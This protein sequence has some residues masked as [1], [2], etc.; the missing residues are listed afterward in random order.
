MLH[1][2]HT[3]PACADA[4]ASTHASATCCLITAGLGSMF[5]SHELL[6][7]AVVGANCRL[8]LVCLKHYSTSATY[9]LLHTQPSGA[10]PP[11]LFHPCC[12]HVVYHRD[13][14]YSCSCCVRVFCS[15]TMLLSSQIVNRFPWTA[16]CMSE[17]CCMWWCRWCNSFDARLLWKPCR[18]AD[19]PADCT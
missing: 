14:R 12:R 15:L 5:N 16:A 18:A 17:T 11:L 10:C 19:C 6:L 3:P 13:W 2:A 1:P 8:L 9:T 7:P 4:C